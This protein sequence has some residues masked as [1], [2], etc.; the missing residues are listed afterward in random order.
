MVGFSC[1]MVL[2]AVATL[3]RLY[4]R[5]SFRFLKTILW[6]IILTGA[7]SVIDGIVIL[8]ILN[9]SKLRQEHE[10][11]YYIFLAI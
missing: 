2:M 3:I 7:V 6:I 8:E 11:I 4:R 9:K 1:T 5:Q 10:T